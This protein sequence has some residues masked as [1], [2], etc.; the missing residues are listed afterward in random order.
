MCQ[1]LALGVLSNSAQHLASITG[2]VMTRMPGE[3]SSSLPLPLLLPLPLPMFPL[4]LPF[5]AHGRPGQP[6]G[7]PAAIA[8]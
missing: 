5:P 3:R 1:V 8:N 6:G 4:P 7:K 2:G